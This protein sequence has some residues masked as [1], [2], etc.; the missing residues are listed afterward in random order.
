MTLIQDLITPKIVTTIVIIST[1]EIT[2][3][4]KAEIVIN[5][6]KEVVVEK[7][8]DKKANIEGVIKTKEKIGVIQK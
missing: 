2:V 4:A 3:K 6:T 7:E 5:I 1:V 8:K